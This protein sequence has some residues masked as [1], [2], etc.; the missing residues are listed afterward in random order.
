MTRVLTICDLL[1][2]LLWLCGQVSSAMGRSRHNL[3][4]AL[5]VVCL[6]MLA[7]SVFLSHRCVRISHLRN[8]YLLDDLSDPALHLY[9]QISGGQP[10]TLLLRNRPALTVHYMWCR[11]GHLEFKHYLS[12]LSVAKV[13]KPDQIVFHYL[14]MPETDKKR[15]FTWFEDI[16]REVPMITL[17]PIHNAKHCSHQFSS[18][19]AKNEDFPNNDGVF[20]VEDI[21]ITNLS[22]EAFYRH[23][24]AH[25]L[26]ASRC[27]EAEGTCEGLKRIPAQMFLVPSSEPYHLT[28]GEGRAVLECPTIDVFN[29]ANVS[30]CLQLSQRLFPSD[31]WRQ[32]KTFDRFARWVAYNHPNPMKPEPDPDRSAPSV[33][34]VLKVDGEDGLSPLCYASVLSAVSQGLM[35]HVFLHGHLDTSADNA[36]WRQ[37]ADKVP[38]THIP[39]PSLD[40]QTTSRQWSLYGLQVLLQYG[41]VVLSCDTI[42]QKPLQPLLQ[43]PAVASVQKSIYRIVHHHMDLSL[44]VARPASRYLQTLIPVFQQMVEVQSPGDVG[45]VAYHM[46]EQYPTSLHLHTHLVAHL[47]CKM[48]RCVASPGQLDV[49]QAYTVQLTWTEGAPPST[50]Q[51]WSDLSTPLHSLASLANPLPS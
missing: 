43:Y 5:M 38:V 10:H 1:W 30:T 17:K 13:L 37:L 20:M 51:Q 26:L 45:A 24:G 40:Q 4:A 19:F 23:T 39:T 6:A 25:G 41:G 16:Q 34:H 9:D 44:L 32:N 28:G 21:A 48:D 18:G 42:V 46:Y 2:L 14:Q 22:R 8:P 15:Y 27:G 47:T 7:L 36:L 50:S 3:Q 35:S 29:K 33:A 11:N 12:L 31:I 49:R